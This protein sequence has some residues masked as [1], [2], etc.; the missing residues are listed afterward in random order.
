MRKARPSQPRLDCNPIP[1]LEL[2]FDCRDEIVPI[3]AAL[4]HVYTKP[5]LRDQIL[6][7]VAQDVNRDSRSDHGRQGLEYWQIVVLAAVRLGCN[8]NYDR[9]QDL[10]ENH[11]KLRYMMGIGDWAEDV[12]F[13]WRR[14]RDNICLLRPET[15]V[16]ISR[17]IVQEGHE[18]QPEAAKSV[19]VDS[20]VMETNIHYPTESS[21]IWDGLRKIITLAAELANDLGMPGWRQHEHLL[22]RIRN[23]QRE[24]ARASASKS[25]KTK[26]RLKRLYAALLKRCQDILGRADTLLENAVT[27]RGDQLAQLEQVR[28]FIGRTRQVA[29][30]AHRRVILD[31]K[32]PNAD[33]LFSIFEPH[34]QLYR[35]GK[36]GQENQFG[37]LVLVYEDGAGFITHHYLMG[38]DERD[39]EVA[40][41]QT[42]QLQERLGNTID[43]ISFDRGFHSP[44]NASALEEIVAN[45]CLPSR[46]PNEYSEQMKNGTVE[47]RA[48]RQ[49][50]PGVESAIG[51]L[52]SGNG[53]KRSRDRSEGG[54]E[55]YLGL[56][57][58][59]R[60]L[61]VLGKLLIAEASP[62][63]IAAQSKRQEAA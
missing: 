59:G 49:R 19:R 37:R 55:R 39:A 8:L 48:A 56:A 17:L 36:A 23:L 46:S 29:S 2:N 21:L 26:K 34:T 41:S 60:N 24:I 16:E 10:A 42:K 22:R 9:L 45:P 54:F 7:L 35:R 4:K 5:E 52:Q 15:I 33:K 61:H 31:E 1:E 53:L 27:T 51:A 44:E 58:L 12:S 47:F 11:R 6:T 43:K 32:V 62:E 57:I 14:I 63:S 30:T 50:H 3:L 28:V 40:V 38:R 25:P 18:L 13:N 20:F